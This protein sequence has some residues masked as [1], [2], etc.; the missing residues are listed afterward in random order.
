[1]LATYYTPMEV[2]YARTVIDK[3]TRLLPSV[4]P[5]RALISTANHQAHR[6]S[7]YDLSQIPVSTTPDDAFYILKT[8]LSRMLSTAS[9][10]TVERTSDRLRDVMDKDYARVIKHKLDNVYRGAVGPGARAEKVERENRQS[11]I[12]S[13]LPQYTFVIALRLPRRSY[14]TTSTFRPHTWNAWSKTWLNQT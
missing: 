11:F 12:V 8:V 1:M 4:F 10:R 7:T 9:V 2:W 3:V 14:S 13:V 6:L 5:V